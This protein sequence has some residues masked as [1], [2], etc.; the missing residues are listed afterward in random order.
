MQRRLA[1]ARRAHD[2]GE[3]AGGELDVD[4]VEGADGGVALAVHLDG[5][6]GPGGDGRPG[7]RWCG[8]PP[9]S[10]GEGAVMECS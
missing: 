7:R 5:V 3:A 10:G 1:R 4:A 2:G 6:D 9:G 8:G